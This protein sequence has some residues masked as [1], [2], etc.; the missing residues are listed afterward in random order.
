LRLFESQFTCFCLF[1]RI[2]QTI[3][4]EVRQAF[5]LSGEQIVWNAIDKLTW[6]LSIL[7]PCWC[8]HYIWGG[9]LGQQKVLAFIRKFYG[10]WL[11][12]F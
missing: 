4:D 10:G 8:L 6:F 12:F 5:H 1:R 7:L 2:L 9:R 3:Q 11:V